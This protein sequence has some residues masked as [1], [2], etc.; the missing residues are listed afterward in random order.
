MPK[1]HIQPGELFSS[2][3]LGFT[4]VVKSTPGTQVFIA[5][6]VGY[7]KSFKIVGPGDLAAQ[8]EKA[9]SNLGHALSAAG[10]TPAD[11]TMLRVYIA[12]YDPSLFAKIHPLIGAFFGDSPPPAQTVLGVQALAGPDILIE[13]EAVAVIDDMTDDRRM[14]GGHEG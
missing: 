9:L 5:G 8:T 6:Q 1:E 14:R 10:A 12:N 4:Q 7:D 13:L 2:Q 11:V 3:N